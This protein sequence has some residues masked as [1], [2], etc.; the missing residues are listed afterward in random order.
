MF[1]LSEFYKIFNYLMIIVVFW[2]G[3]HFVSGNH[4][5]LHT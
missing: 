4:P 5:F 1:F 3:R 2:Y